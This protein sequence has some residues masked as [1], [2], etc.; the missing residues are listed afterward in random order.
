MGL[1]E[2]EQK[3][4]LWFSMWLKQ[5]DLGILKLFDKHAYYIESWGPEYHG[6]KEIEYWFREFNTRGKVIQWQ[7]KQFFHK[8]NQ[9]IVEWYF[10]VKMN[11]EPI[12]SFDGI[13]LVK[14][15]KDDQ[16]MFLQEFGS[17]RKRYNP[18]EKGKKPE[19]RNENTPWF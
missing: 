18:Y 4:Q 10:K 2:R 8:G 19:F 17:N 14:W 11:D 7:I 16:I 9:T 6:A 5:T 13:S 12:N 15:N 3:I 1:D